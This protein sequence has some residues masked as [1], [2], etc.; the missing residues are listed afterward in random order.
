MGKE[1]ANKHERY[2]LMV[3]GREELGR[4]NMLSRTQH[5]SLSNIYD[6]PA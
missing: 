4:H 3:I 6:L 5:T 1:R 2:D